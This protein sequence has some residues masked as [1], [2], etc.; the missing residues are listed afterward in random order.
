MSEILVIGGAGYIGSHLILKLIETNQ[1]FFV[2]DN[3]STGKINS[4]PKKSLYHGCMSD[5]DLLNV[6]F[7]K[8]Q[9]STVILL[10][11]S[12]DVAES[13]INP[14]NYYLNNVANTLKLLDSMI[15]H[16]IKNIIFS[17]TAA[18]F[19]DLNNKA[20]SIDSS[21]NLITPNAKS[22]LMIETILND[23]IKD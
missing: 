10:A 18:V 11:G 15:H 9:I 12:V 19:G 3:L 2:L 20:V 4:I 13:V 6:I 23:F 14:A 7:K 1:K 21:K 5:T 22:K 8:H 16:N 17:S